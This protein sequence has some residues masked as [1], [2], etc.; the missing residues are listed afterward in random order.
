MENEVREVNGYVQNSEGK[1]VLTE[2]AKAESL[3]LYYSG[4]LAYSK[5][6]NL[7]PIGK[8]NSIGEVIPFKPWPTKSVNTAE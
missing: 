5:E 7:H 3:A 6:N 1:W 2:A 8:Y 4:R